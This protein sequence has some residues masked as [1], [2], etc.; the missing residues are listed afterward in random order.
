MKNV[1]RLFLLNSFALGAVAVAASIGGKPVMQS[2]QVHQDVRTWDETIVIT[3]PFTE[4]V[5]PIELPFTP[6]P[7]AFQATLLPVTCG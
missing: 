7:D 5:V 1:L 6:H 3:P 4:F 2:S